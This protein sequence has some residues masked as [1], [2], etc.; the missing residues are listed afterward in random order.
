MLDYQHE[1][2][3]GAPPLSLW[4][5]RRRFVYDG[6]RGDD[7]GRRDIVSEENRSFWDRL[8]GSSEENEQER[9]VREYIIH[10]VK[11]GRPLRDVLREE[12]VRRNASQTVIENI[13]EDPRLIEAAQEQ[14]REDFSSGQLDPEPPPPSAAR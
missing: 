11:Q 1:L 2:M 3:R 4:P 9:K 10:N 12:Y 13:I 7:S 14:M 6:S 8:F 5:V